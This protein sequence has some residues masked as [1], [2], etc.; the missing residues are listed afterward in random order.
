MREAFHVPGVGRL[1][2]VSD[3]AGALIG[4]IQPD[5]AHALAAA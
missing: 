4:L 2:V 3:G 5:P 1:A